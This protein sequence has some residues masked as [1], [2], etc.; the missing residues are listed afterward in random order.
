MDNSGTKANRCLPVLRARTGDNSE[1][2]RQ[3]PEEIH[4][5]DTTEINLGV[6]SLQLGLLQ[7]LLKSSVQ[8]GA[9]QFKKDNG[10]T[11][12]RSQSRDL[13]ARQ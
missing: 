1:W 11:G 4:L 3:A 8:S 2:R 10:I 9:T 13:R 7:F 5:A 12:E 6:L